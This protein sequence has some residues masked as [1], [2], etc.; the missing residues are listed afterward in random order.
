MHRNTLFATFIATLALTITSAARA[1]AADPK[2]TLEPFVDDKLV[3]VA[4]IDLTRVDVKALDAWVAE[5]MRA[6]ATKG[7]PAE[8]KRVE[9]LIAELAPA[10]QALEQGTAMFRDAGASELYA[11]MTT[12]QLFAEGPPPLL[13]P[14]TEG[15]DPKKLEAILGPTGAPQSPQ[16][17]GK[18]I[19]NALLVADEQTVKRLTDLHD[20]KTKRVPNPDL[21]AAIGMAPEGAAVHVAI[22]MP[23]DARRVFGELV[24]N[25]PPEFGGGPIT[26]VTEGLRWS[27]LSLTLPPKPSLRLTIQARDAASADAL[28]KLLNTARGATVKSLQAAAAGV[29]NENDKLLNKT[30]AEF[31]NKLVHARKDDQL[32]LV[33]DE[34]RLRDLSGVMVAGMFRAREQ[35]KR[36]Q[37]ASQI[38]QLLL[39]CAMWANEHKGEWP[40]DPKAAMKK[41]DVAEEQAKNPLNPATGYTYV[42][43]PKGGKDAADRIAMY[44]TEHGDDGLNVGF[45]DGHVEW[46]V[47][48]QFQDALAKQE[49]NDKAGEAKE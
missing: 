11:L 5:T 38:R 41:F 9:Q 48:K 12:D 2:T 34:P 45:V 26:V 47:L 37:S 23:A 33:I 6:G 4:R 24:P 1:R 17:M 46:M 19:G 15:T 49:K 29:Q 20:D 27:A 14:I 3:A 42:K 7:D 16:R 10:R 40:D 31:V 44:E 25:L 13:I 18:R 8:A 21:L 43:P 39:V 32:L 35:A 28:D 22:A 30:F 36:I